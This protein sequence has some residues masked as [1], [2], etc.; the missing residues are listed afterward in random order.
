MSIFIE[1]LNK[2]KLNN[3]SILKFHCF[4]K[5]FFNLA[6]S[7]CETGRSKKKVMQQC[8]LT[9]VNNLCTLGLIEPYSSD[10]VKKDKL[11]CIPNLLNVVNVN[12]NEKL[13]KDLY[14]LLKDL[15]IKPMIDEVIIITF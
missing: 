6:I 11:N 4:I 7:T 3:L 8:K 9:L 5:S 2:S 12:V 13:V 15:K 10:R 1:Q 14:G